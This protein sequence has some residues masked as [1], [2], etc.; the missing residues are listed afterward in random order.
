MNYYTFLVV[1]VCP[2]MGW[3]YAVALANFWRE[4]IELAIQLMMSIVIFCWLIY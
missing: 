2:L 4:L 1:N 3:L